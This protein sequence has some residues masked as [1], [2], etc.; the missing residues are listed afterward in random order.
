MNLF[1]VGFLLFRQSPH[2]AGGRPP[3]AQVGPKH[4]IIEQLHFDEIQ[5]QIYEELIDEHK[6]TIQELNDKVRETKSELYLTLAQ[7]NTSS[8]D[9]LIKELG[10][11]QQ[12]IETVHYN[13]FIAIKNLCKP[14]QLG[15]FETLTTKLADYFDLARS[16]PRRPE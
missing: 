11:L 4:R 5:V 12:K 15:Y 6:R 10:S 16:A 8:K 1:L 3:F 9:S 14:D 2:P 13:H 7:E